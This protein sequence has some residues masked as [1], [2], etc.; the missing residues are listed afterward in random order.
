MNTYIRNPKR[1]Y[2]S[3]AY[4]GSGQ[5]QEHG[6]SEREKDKKPT[7]TSEKRD[8]VQK[9]G[10]AFDQAADDALKSLDEV[11]EEIEQE[12]AQYQDIAEQH[13]EIGGQ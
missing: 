1:F 2:A 4:S 10:E 13:R 7:Y 3:I 12:S 8:E 6:G 11:L 5:K 9:E